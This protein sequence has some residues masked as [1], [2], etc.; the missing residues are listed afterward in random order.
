MTLPIRVEPIPGESLVSWLAAHATR[1]NC[2]WGEVL[3]IVLPAGTDLGRCDRDLVLVGHLRDDQR[4]AIA[5][6]T[7][8]DPAEVEAMTLAGCYGQQ[9]IAIDPDSGRPDT[10]WGKISRQR[11]CPLCLTSDPGRD[12]LEWLLPWITTCPEHRCYLSDACTHDGHHQ[13]VSP[14]W[15]RL[16]APPL[17]HR[18]RGIVHTPSN[19]RGTR[20]TARLAQTPV[21]RLHCADPILDA[22]Q[23]L[24]DWLS[25]PCV[26]RG[27]YASA[28]V[29]P[30]EALQD[31]LRLTGRLLASADSARLIQFWGLRSTDHRVRYW[32]ETLRVHQAGRDNSKKSARVVAAPSAAVSAWV[33][34]AMQ[35]LTKSSITQAAEALQS[36]NRIT[37]NTAPERPR[38]RCLR[39]STALTAA[40]I[41]S[42]AQRVSVFTK[43][44]DRLDS[45]LPTNTRVEGS[46]TEAMLR[47]VRGGLWTPWCLRLDTGILSWTMLCQT[48]TRLLLARGCTIAGHEANRRLHIHPRANSRIEAAARRLYA[49]PQWHL[50]HEALVRLSRYL[51]VTPPPI[52]YQRRRDINYRSLLTV[53]QWNQLLSSHDLPLPSGSAGAALARNWLTEQLGGPPARDAD[54]RLT[55]RDGPREV[56]RTHLTPDLLAALDAI[57]TDFLHTRGITDEPLRWTPPIALLDGLDLPG[58]IPAAAELEQADDLI[59]QRYTVVRACHTLKMTPE[60]VRYHLE[61]HPRAKHTVHRPKP[62]PTPALDWLRT[63]LP[64]PKLRDLYER[65]QL[66]R[67]TILNLVAAQYGRTCDRRTLETL[68]H[69][70]G[71]E[72]RA[73]PRPAPAWIHAQHVIGRRRL[74]DMAA[75]L[76][77]PRYTISYYAQRYGIPTHRSAWWYDPDPRSLQLLDALGIDPNTHHPRL[78]STPTWND[79]QI[80]ITTSQ[81]AS[82][83]AA[84]QALDR[85]PGAISAHIRTLESLWAASM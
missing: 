19:Y 79:L 80:L 75:E 49:Q 14:T 16:L 13:C 40:D 2:W 74:T 28:P 62:R 44:N 76:G 23:T 17:T 9:L 82:F 67:Q 33:T 37:T 20:C 54:G 47:A 6:A 36:A 5:S 69:E 59:A 26:D 18:C 38:N 21:D 52:D 81:H 63:V 72:H 68:M 53:G 66:A 58:I 57:A 29:G 31:I 45:E 83:S 73:V 32:N 8:S 22:Q 60:A 24:I 50:T 77:V 51:K 56:L 61:Q 30:D 11:F 85:S 42:R 10:P 4:D 48:L 78:A 34:T 35:I 15:F 39:Y 41:M 43:L 46:R 70:Q 1:M 71:I 25:R 3:Q 55:R 65:K 27:L 64:E 84:A 7:H 12:R